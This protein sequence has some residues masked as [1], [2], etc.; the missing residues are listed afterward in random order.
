M[1]TYTVHERED[2]S[3]NIA[4]RAD[5]VVFVREGFAWLA[6]FVP[7]LWLAYYRMWIVLAGFVGVLAAMQIGLAAAGLADDAAAWATIA[8]S[9]VFAFQANDLRRWS[10][11]RRGYRFA[12][13]VTGSS[14]ADCEAQFFEAW[15]AAQGERGD[16]DPNQAKRI[17]KSAPAAKPAAIPQQRDQ[18]PAGGD[19]VIGL[20]PDSSR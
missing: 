3:G 17:T 18:E 16:A 15:L 6:L 5:G 20:F 10:L 14:R 12:G 4:E 9:L 11:A 8:L 7:V 1:V 2:A 13:P 19:D